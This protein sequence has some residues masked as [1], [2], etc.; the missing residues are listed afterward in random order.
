VVLR[1]VVSVAQS[2]RLE[3]RIKNIVT[4]CVVVVQLIKELCK[5]IMKIKQ[6]FLVLKDI[7][8]VE[9]F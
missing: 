3:K 8:L 4:V 5:G 2:L 6:G 9:N 1:Y 7:V